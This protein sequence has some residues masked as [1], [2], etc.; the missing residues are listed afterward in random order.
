MFYKLVRV[1]KPKTYVYGY[2]MCE[3]K[4]PVKPHAL[5]QPFVE[6]YTSSWLIQP[7]SYLK[8]SHAQD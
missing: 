5:D 2:E 8:E 3:C 4:D 1:Y 7:S 6:G